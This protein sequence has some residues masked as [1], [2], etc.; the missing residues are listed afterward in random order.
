MGSG[1]VNHEAEQ[2]DRATWREALIARILLLIAAM[3]AGDRETA[4]R[5]HALHCHINV[6]VPG[7][8]R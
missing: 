8:D 4:K 2:Q 7:G 6:R 3:F 5:I 1:S